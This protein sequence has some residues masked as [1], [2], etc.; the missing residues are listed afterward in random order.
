LESSEWAISSNLKLANPIFLGK[1]QLEE[2][3]HEDLYENFS[4]KMTPKLEDQIFE[5]RDALM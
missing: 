3:N 4:L 2:E 5:V 1:V